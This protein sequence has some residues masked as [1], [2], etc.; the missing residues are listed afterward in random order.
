MLAAAGSGV[1]G[2]ARIEAPF[3]VGK[4][5]C[6]YDVTRDQNCLTPSTQLFA[7]GVC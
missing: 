5:A 3:P 2:Q 6:T 4:G 7:R 1:H